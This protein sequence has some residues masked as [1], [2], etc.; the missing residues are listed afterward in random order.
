M[1]PGTFCVGSGTARR[2]QPRCS[3]KKWQKLPACVRLV[4]HMWLFAQTQRLIGSSEK[5]QPWQQVLW[6]L[7]LN[8]AIIYSASLGSF[9]G[10][11]GQDLQP[12]C[13][14]LLPRDG[15]SPEQA[16]RGVPVAPSQIM[17][18]LSPA[19]ALLQSLIL[20]VQKCDFPLP[21]CT[22]SWHLC[23]SERSSLKLLK[24]KREN[25]KD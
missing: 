5:F 15:W 6:H 22:A 3:K 20:W 10:K 1:P 9:G 24:E 7:V 11:P 18:P 4:T 17:A 13:W 21:S 16:E 12:E 23:S 19:W 25:Q 2:V 8:T 14:W